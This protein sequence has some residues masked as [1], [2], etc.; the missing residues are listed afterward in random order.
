MGEPTF[1]AIS[2]TLQ[3]FS[4]CAS[5]NA[6]PNTV[7]SLAKANTLR[8]FTVPHD[9]REPLQLTCTDGAARLARG[10]GLVARALGLTL[11]HDGVDRRR[12]LV[13]ASGGGAAGR[14]ADVYMVNHDSDRAWDAPTFRTVGDRVFQTSAAV[15]VQFPRLAQMSLGR[16]V[17]G[18]WR[19]GN[20]P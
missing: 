7:K 17:S 12:Q 19:N 2:I 4:A 9:A 5:D 11:E 6:P 14:G 15:C 16:P 8:P 3:I 1:N 10:P 20:G 18:S 13:S